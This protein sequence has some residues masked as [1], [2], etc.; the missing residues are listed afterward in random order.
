MASD[1][2]RADI[3][4]IAT[5]EG[6]FNPLASTM[7]CD[8]TADEIIERV[9]PEDGPMLVEDKARATYFVPAGLRVAPFVGRTAERYP[10]QSGYQRSSSH[11]VG[12]SW[13][14]FDLDGLSEAEWL[15]IYGRLEA[16]DAQYCAYSSYSRGV[17]TGARVRLLLFMDRV[18]EPQEWKTAWD[19]VDKHVL[20]GLADKATA[21]LSQQAGCWATHA[22]RVDMAFRFFGGRRPLSADKLLAKAPRTKPKPTRTF[23]GWTGRREPERVQ[24]ALCWLD[25]NRYDEWVATCLG[26]KAGVRLGHINEAEGF[27]LWLAFSD[28]ADASA[29]ANNDATQYDPEAMWDRMEPTAAPPEALFGKLLAR[30]RDEAMRHVCGAISSKQSTS[31]AEEAA[32]YLGAY[33]SRAMEGVLQ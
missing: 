29:K 23:S 16:S 19:V 21:R 18:L 26:L 24:R 6:T 25:P 20:D 27:Q 30:A 32:H 15:R 8:L 11:V 3:H 9:A 31:R 5:F 4:C 7:E 2:E 33:H 14:A 13:F 17:K 22:D 1:S 12:G 28:R 10:G